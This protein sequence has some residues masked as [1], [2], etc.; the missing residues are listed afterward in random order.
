MKKAPVYI[1]IILYLILCTTELYSSEITNPKDSIKVLESESKDR[2]IDLIAIGGLGFAYCIIDPTWSSNFYSFVPALSFGVEIP[3]TK[4]H[5]WSIEIY[6]HLWGAK[7]RLNN[8]NSF[9]SDPY[10]QISE[11]IFSQFGTSAALKVYFGRKNSNIRFS[12]HGGYMLSPNQYYLGIDLGFSIYYYL[13]NDLSISMNNRFLLGEFNVAG[14][15]Y[16]YAP[17]LMTINLN[18]KLKTGKKK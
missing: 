18:Y 6:S 14:G 12:F 9:Y 10:I 8:S 13:N 15:G 16:S 3:F 1:A 11:N 2:R 4:K 5:I 17:N 7:K